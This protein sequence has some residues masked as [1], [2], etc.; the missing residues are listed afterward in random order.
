MKEGS[1]WIEPNISRETEPPAEAMAKANV[2]HRFIAKFIDL[3]IV[4]AIYEI[5]L[6]VSF[7]A[8]LAYL[9]L[10]DGFGGGRSPGKRLIGLLVVLPRHRRV[11]SFRESIIRNF[12]LALAYL[13]FFV[14]L[15]GWLA[16]ALILAVEGLLVIGNSQGLRVGDEIAGTQVVD[17]NKFQLAEE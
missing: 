11:C 5:P 1:A 6:R 8:A 7:I 10:A 3:L 4:T 14:P 16:T 13:L 17:Q 9:L 2:L 12:P 15:I